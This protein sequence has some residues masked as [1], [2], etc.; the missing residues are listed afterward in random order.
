MIVWCV[1]CA[2][3]LLVAY[4]VLARNRSSTKLSGRHV[5]VSCRTSCDV[6]YVQNFV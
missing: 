1:V 6:M 2:V 5:L 3:V 4:L